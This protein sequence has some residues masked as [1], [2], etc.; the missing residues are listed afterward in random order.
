MRK[1]FVFLLLTVAFVFADEEKNENKYLRMPLLYGRIQLNPGDLEMTVRTDKQNYDMCE[2]ITL[3]V[4]FRNNTDKPISI[5]KEKY[6]RYFHDYIITVIPP[7]KETIPENIS[8][9]YLLPFKDG[10]EIDHA[11]GTRFSKVG[12]GWGGIKNRDIPPHG[13]TS[14]RMSLSRFFD[15]T[16]PGGVYTVNVENARNGDVSFKATTTFEVS[17]K[18]ASSTSVAINDMKY[19]L[20]RKK[21]MNALGE[22]ANAI[23][24]DMEKD[25]VTN[26]NDIRGGAEYGRLMMILKTLEDGSKLDAWH[27][28]EYLEKNNKMTIKD[29]RN[30]ICICCGWEIKD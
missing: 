5:F 6:G 9:L 3:I 8:F 13:T 14:F 1:F 27:N 2:P 23:L 19:M 21:I 16:Y 7:K 20:G 28:M 10:M 22:E 26:I 11:P 24:A 12:L 29:L 4:T 30:F 18:D 17:W 25:G 15:L